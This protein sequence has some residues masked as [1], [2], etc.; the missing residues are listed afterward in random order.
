MRNIR[1]KIIHNVHRISMNIQRKSIDFGESFPEKEHPYNPT[2]DVCS[3]ISSASTIYFRFPFP[4]LSRQYITLL[5][6]HVIVSH[7]L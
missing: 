6:S 3:T 2:N 5:S 1:E 7:N 4:L